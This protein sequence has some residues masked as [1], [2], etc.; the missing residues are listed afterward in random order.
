MPPLAVDKDA[1]G[2]APGGRAELASGFVEVT[3][4][5]MLRNG[6]LAGD[7]LGRQV[8]RHQTQTLALARRQPPERLVRAEGF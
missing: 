5:R 1:D 3:V 7:L 6:Q 2:V 4:H 8:S